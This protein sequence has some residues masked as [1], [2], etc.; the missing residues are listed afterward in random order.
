[1]LNATIWRL[2]LD[3]TVLAVC[4]AEIDAG[5]VFMVP[6]KHVSPE[7][8]QSFHEA[9]MASHDAWLD[10]PTE[11]WYSEGT[12]GFDEAVKLGFG[13]AWFAVQT[14]AKKIT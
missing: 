7:A 1:M 10:E 14:R 8:N 11:I 5:I 9:F 12:E 2:R 6:G 3:G 13:I 4:R